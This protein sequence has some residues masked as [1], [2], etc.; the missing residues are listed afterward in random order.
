MIHIK[1]TVTHHSRKPRR[2]GDFWWPHQSRGCWVPK[3]QAE[4]RFVDQD[5]QEYLQSR[6]EEIVTVSPSDDVA[7]IKR[8]I[9]ETREANRFVLKED[10]FEIVQK[11]LQSA[12][13]SLVFEYQVAVL[14]IQPTDE[15]YKLEL[16]S[17]VVEVAYPNLLENS[18]PENKI[19]KIDENID[20]LVIIASSDGLVSDLGSVTQAYE[21]NSEESTGILQI[22]ISHIEPRVKQVDHIESMGVVRTIMGAHLLERKVTPEL[23]VYVKI[24]TGGLEASDE[25]HLSNWFHNLP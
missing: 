21:A 1:E 12:G 8:K 17:K 18:F 5:G 6:M 20:E 23:D 14:K 3:V 11:V 19:L 22:Y 4:E 9:L 15:G 13:K 7:E 16:V 25:S 10:R 24:G 2:S